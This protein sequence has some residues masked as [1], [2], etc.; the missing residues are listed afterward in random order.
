MDF[1]ALNHP[2]QA[3]ALVWTNTGEHCVNLI[4]QVKDVQDAENPMGI[5]MNVNR[6]IGDKLVTN[7]VT[8][9]SVTVLNATGIQA[10]A[11]IVSG[12]IGGITVN[13][14]AKYHIVDMIIVTKTQAPV[15]G[16]M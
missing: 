15:V 10:F 2:D 12:D 13:M 11:Q 1:R 3:V 9:P 8:L 14:I 6:D 16:V 7:Y 4:A 5:V